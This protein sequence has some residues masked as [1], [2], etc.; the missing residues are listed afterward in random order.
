M[1]IYIINTVFEV[2]NTRAQAGQQSVDPELALNYTDCGKRFI[3]VR[4][5]REGV[6]KGTMGNGRGMRWARK[7]GGAQKWEGEEGEK[8]PLMARMLSG[9]FPR[10]QTQV[11]ETGPLEPGTGGSLSSGRAPAEEGPL[12]EHEV[13][14]FRLLLITS[15]PRGPLSALT[16]RSSLAICV[17]WFICLFV[18][19]LFYL[20]VFLCLFILDRTEALCVVDRSLK[21]GF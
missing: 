6:R 3:K 2:H 5:A 4:T 11:W 16:F 20:F 15:H 10:E 17:H 9:Y 19:L 21:N 14:V 1:P 18:F 13:A 7:R 12:F 8:K